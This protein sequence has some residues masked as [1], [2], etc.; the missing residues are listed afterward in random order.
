MEINVFPKMYVPCLCV[1]TVI[2]E[3]LCSYDS[4]VRIYAVVIFYINAEHWK[5]SDSVVL[6]TIIEGEIAGKCF[7]GRRRTAWIDDVRHG[8]V[9]VN[10]WTLVISP[11]T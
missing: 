4:S 3:E 10:V 6:A 7:P 2:S 1:N 5:R 9:K 8:Q 11:L